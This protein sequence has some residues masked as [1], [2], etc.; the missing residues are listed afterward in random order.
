MANK[1]IYLD[2]GHGGKDPGAVKHVVERDVNIKV[3]EF[4]HDY[5]KNNYVCSLKKDISGDS[6]SAICKRANDWKADIFISVHFNAGGGDGYE[7]LVYGSENKAMGE[8]FAKHVKSAGQNLRNPAVKL[9]PELI[10]LNA[11]NMQA[12][13]NEIAFVDNWKDI[14][15]WNEDAELKVMAQALGE[16][17]AEWLSLPKK[18][19]TPKTTKNTQTEFVKKVQSAIGANVDGKAGPETFSKTVTVSAIKNRRHKVV[20]VI[21]EHLNALGYPCGVADGIA[22]PKFDKA[23]KMYQKDHNCV[24]DGEI[25]SMGKTWKTLLQMK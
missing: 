19:E 1:K 11:T 24:V 18:V 6:L 15:D 21:Q 10:V 3:I 25:T 13:L 23:V 14:Q 17:T 16:A 4:L 22:G 20:K 8:C 7:A 5:L 12:I 2:A 9:R